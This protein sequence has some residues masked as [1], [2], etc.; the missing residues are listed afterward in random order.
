MVIVV[1]DIPDEG[2]RGIFFVSFDQQG[3][4]EYFR[5]ESKDLTQ[6]TEGQYLNKINDNFSLFIEQK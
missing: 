1:D 3:Q 6:A 2:S 5:A 4:Q